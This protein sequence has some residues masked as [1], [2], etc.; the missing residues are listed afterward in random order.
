MDI[1]TLGPYMLKELEQQVAQIK[2]NIKVAQDM[3]KI[4]TYNKRTHKEFKV[5]DYVYL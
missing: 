2:K 5:G 3:K 4:Y 1:I